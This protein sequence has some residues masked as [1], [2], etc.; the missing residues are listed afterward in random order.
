VA[1]SLIRE[2]AKG[3]HL[4]WV[5]QYGGGDEEGTSQAFKFMAKHFSQKSQM[6]IKNLT[7]K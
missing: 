4:T 5:L 6:K 7:I 1:S 2:G 3:W